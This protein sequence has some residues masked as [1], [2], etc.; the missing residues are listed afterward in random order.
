MYA[1]STPDQNLR[2]VAEAF[3]NSVHFLCKSLLRALYN[4]SEVNES[5][6]CVRINHHDK[7]IG[8]NRRSISFLPVEEQNRRI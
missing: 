7:I 6:V 4:A 3:C 5:R 2:E 8:A 1:I